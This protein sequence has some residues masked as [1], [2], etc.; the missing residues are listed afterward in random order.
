MPTNEVVI[1]QAVNKALKGNMTAHKLVYRL[2]VQHGLVLP[3]VSNNRRCGV[4]EVDC[5][6]SEEEWHARNDEQN[7]KLSRS[8]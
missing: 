4:L 8:R 3:V 2:M 1:R 6:I 5:W 7:K